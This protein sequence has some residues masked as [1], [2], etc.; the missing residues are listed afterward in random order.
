M[1][2]YIYILYIFIK[3]LLALKVKKGGEKGFFEVGVE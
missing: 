2:G 3:F 1:R